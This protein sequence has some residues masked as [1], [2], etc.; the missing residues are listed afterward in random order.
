M[1][2]TKKQQK[3]DGVDVGIT[4]ELEIET[5]TKVLDTRVLTLMNKKGLWFWF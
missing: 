4:T 3:H 5:R 1:T 2:I